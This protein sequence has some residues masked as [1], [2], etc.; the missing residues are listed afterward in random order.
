MR[1]LPSQLEVS[2][3]LEIEARSGCLQLADARRSFLDEYLDCFGVTQRRAGCQSVAPM[4]L[5]RISR[6][7]RCRNSTLCVGCCAIEQRALGEHHHLAFRRC[8]KRRVQTR[9]A[10]SD[11]EKACP[12]AV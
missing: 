11:D 7:Q 3:R 6:A 4:E 5:R 9:N 8:A 12:N 2:A 1:S 10:A